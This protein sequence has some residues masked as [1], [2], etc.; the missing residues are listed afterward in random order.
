MKTKINLALALYI[1][2]VIADTLF[3]FTSEFGI[4]ENQEDW[5]KAGGA[6]VAAV[7][8]IFN[9]KDLIKTNEN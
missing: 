6:I 9:N 7:I 2:I 4:P 1:L 8:G 5:M 3:K